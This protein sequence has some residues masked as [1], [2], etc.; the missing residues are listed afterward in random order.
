MVIILSTGEISWVQ[1]VS[2]P[3]SILSLTW[4]A[5]RAFFIQR[6]HDELDADPNAG[7]ILL[8]VYP[9][10]FLM[11]TNS[12]ILW[13]TIGGLLGKYIFFGFIL[14]FTTVLWSLWA[15]NMHETNEFK[16]IIILQV[17]LVAQVYI[18]LGISAF[19]LGPK[20]T[21]FVF[22]LLLIVFLTCLCVVNMRRKDLDERKEVELEFVSVRQM[23]KDENDKRTRSGGKQYFSLKSALTST[24]LPCVVGN[25]SHTFI[26]SAIVSLVNKILILVMAVLV[27]EWNIVDTNVFLVWCKENVTSDHDDLFHRIKPCYNISSCMKSGDDGLVQKVRVCGDQ[28]SEMLVRICL[29]SIILVTTL[30]ST[31]AAYKL[32]KISDYETFYERTKTFMGKKTEQFVHHSLV[33]TFASSDSKGQNLEDILRSR[34]THEMVNRV[35]NGETALHVSTERGADKCTEI[36]LKNKA[37]PKENYNGN[38]PEI[39]N[40]LTN[41]QILGCL[42]QAV[43]KQENRYSNYFTIQTS[44]RDEISDS[45][46][47]KLMLQKNTDGLTPIQAAYNDTT[48][49]KPLLELALSYGYYPDLEIPEE[50]VTNV[51]KLC[52]QDPSD[53]SSNKIP[54]LHKAFQRLERALVGKIILSLII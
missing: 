28:F 23:A 4:S 47:R 41:K 43:K 14:C 31:L 46:I 30:L 8:R 16:I 50:A 32:H 38:V 18:F 39:A 1:Y 17:Y 34:T 37:V 29:F 27:V 40:F 20:S 24:W 19:G 21:L 12:T 9:W 22:C 10:M 45:A 25:K 35:R 15:V 52:R 6:G 44:T 49:L 36:L 48:L 33:F 11:V 53:F 42:L 7:N 26:T 2:I 13:T 3:W 5:S 54:N 51:L